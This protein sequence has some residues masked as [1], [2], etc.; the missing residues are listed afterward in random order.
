MFDISYL[1]FE[2]VVFK[3]ELEKVVE[4]FFKKV[5]YVDYFNLII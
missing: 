5:I 3:N 4:V 2:L 1:F